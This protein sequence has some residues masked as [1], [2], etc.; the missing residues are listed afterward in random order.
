MGFLCLTSPKSTVPTC[1]TVAKYN[2]GRVLKVL[3]LNKKPER[4]M[5]R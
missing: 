5:F 4:I 2:Y 1:L 3:K